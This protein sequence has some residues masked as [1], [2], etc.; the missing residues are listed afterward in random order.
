MIFK[1]VVYKYVVYKGPGRRLA[2]GVFRSKGVLLQDKHDSS[3]LTE[4][5]RMPPPR[6]RRNSDSAMSRY[7]SSLFTGSS[8]MAMS[9]GPY[10]VSISEL[11]RRIRRDS[12]RNPTN[13]SI[14]LIFTPHFPTPES[15]LHI[16]VFM[17]V[18]WN[19]RAVSCRIWAE[20]VDMFQELLFKPRSLTGRSPGA[21]LCFQKV[22]SHTAHE[23]ASS[24]LNPP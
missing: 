8:E 6:S 16:L 5:Y 2:T 12:F 4:W 3:L 17:T 9:S 7:H 19:R 20:V 1:F 11:R 21:D 23:I 10:L 18:K 24:T 13:H 15:H 14:R 22:Q